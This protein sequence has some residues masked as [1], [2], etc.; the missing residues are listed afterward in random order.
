MECIIRPATLRG[1]VAAPPSKS[2]AHRLLI[3]AALADKPTTLV[4]PGSSDDVLA[5][6][7]CLT[8]LG[9]KIT[10]GSEKLEIIPIA[11]V[12]EDPLLDC[13]ESGSTLRFLLPVAAAIAPGARFIGREG[14]ARRPISVLCDCLAEG[15]AEFD[16]KSLP[17]TVKGHIRP[18]TYRIPGNE[19]SQYISGLLFALS[20]MEEE[21][22][23]ELIAALESKGYVDMT[24]SALKHFGV[25]WE[26]GDK[27]W[28]KPA[29]QKYT[30][31][32][33][34]RVEGDWSGAAFTLAAGALHGPVKV[35]GLDRDS[36]QRDKYIVDILEK[37]GAAISWENDAVTV[38]H[39]PLHGCRVDLSDI[40]DLG[41]IIA[42]VAAA[43]EGET[44]LENAGRLRIKETDRILTVCEMVNGLGGD[45]RDMGHS[46]LIYGKKLTGGRVTSAGDHRIAM[47]A[48]VAA[49]VCSG[50]TVLH[51]P[52]AVRKSYPG[53]YGDY[54]KLGGSIDGIELR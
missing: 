24:L 29:G 26:A 54:T 9:A 21:C 42:A 46:V 53:F 28:T 30:S 2:A 8:A 5:T 34:L 47:S 12:P 15:G 6:V 17:L 49:S 50:E 7:R 1:T 31:P 18:G 23:I 48:A 51:D 10:G 52:M 39:R 19:S 20:S 11:N 32:G 4:N 44:V 22:E 43:A 45:A 35:M 16:G 38:E 37:F 40:P 33:T 25:Q 14:L 36:L 13:G 3:A 41:P 27:G